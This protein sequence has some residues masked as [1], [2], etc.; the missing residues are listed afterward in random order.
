MTKLDFP[1]TPSTGE[2]FG[3][4]GT[5][6]RWDG[7]RWGS[8]A[9]AA[10]ARG[11]VAYAQIVADQYPITTQTAITGLTVTVMMD[12][13]R[14]YRVTAYA[15]I[16]NGNAGERVLFKLVR[17]GTTT[18]AMDDLPSAVGG[19]SPVNMCQAVISGLSGSHTFVPTVERA[20]GTGSVGV[21]AGIDNP[22]F[23]LV[24]DITYEAGSGGPY[25]D[26]ASLPKGKLAANTWNV[27]QPGFAATYSTVSG[28]PLTAT[29]V[30]DRILRYSW[31]VVMQQ[32]VAA[33]LQTFRV[34]VNGTPYNVYNK[35][36]SLGDVNTIVGFLPF[37]VAP[38]TVNVSLLGYVAGGQMNNLSGS[39]SYSQFLLEDLGRA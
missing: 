7:T 11:R 35:Q 13:S 9:G 30:A 5:V 29:T 28:S 8:T 39:Y 15:R 26:V 1:D 16:N 23:I 19:Y 24:E 22:A 14:T 6:W 32:T 33:A 3:S 27:D 2:Q 12:P 18:I 36:A 38:G 4:S 21:K 34:L 31:S 37:G 10:G 20:V 17:D 25:I